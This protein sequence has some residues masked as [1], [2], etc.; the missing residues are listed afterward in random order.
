MD[1]LFYG[2]FLA[3][4]FVVM[5][6]VLIRSSPNNKLRLSAWLEAS[7]RAQEEIWAAKRGIE[8]QQRIYQRTREVALLRKEYP[9]K[10]RTV[11]IAR[12]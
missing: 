9:E 5:F 10:P 6:L 4:A 2:S 1:L 11:E 7:A 3:N 12:G 8:E